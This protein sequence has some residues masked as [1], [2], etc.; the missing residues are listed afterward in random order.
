MLNNIQFLA[1]TTFFNTFFVIFFALGSQSMEAQQDNTQKFGEAFEL[2][3]QPNQDARVFQELKGNESTQALISGSITEVCQT[4]GCW[5]KVALSDGEEVF[6]RFKDYGFFVP[7]N[8]A[9][10]SVIMNGK[11]FLE[12][13][14]V[15]DQQHY[16]MDKGASQEE[17][18]AI[19]SPKR[20][21]RFE[22]EGVLIQPKS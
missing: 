4:K 2:S 7:T 1:K 17:I 22:A 16:A 10:N 21:Y 3:A 11:A 9:G 15:E 18:N 14:S 8:S 5:M 19:T 13:M 12:E 20:T 6:V